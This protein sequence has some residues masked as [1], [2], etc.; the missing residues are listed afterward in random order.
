MSGAESVVLTRSA[1][2][3]F[4]SCSAGTVLPCRL[5]KQHWVEAQVAG[6]ERRQSLSW[7]NPRDCRSLGLHWTRALW[8][9]APS[10][11]NVRMAE[12]IQ[13]ACC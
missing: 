2:L 3:A 5:C 9:N 13:R 12:L 4:P 10:S 8:A 11:D 6:P 1:R 7:A